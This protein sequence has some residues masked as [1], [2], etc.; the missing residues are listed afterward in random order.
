M[1]ASLQGEGWAQ[2]FAKALIIVGIL[3]CAAPIVEL[4]V[5]SAGG[6]S[7]PEPFVARGFEVDD[8]ADPFT[9]LSRI[10]QKASSHQGQMPVEVIEEMGVLPGAFESKVDAEN[11]IVGYVVAGDA[12]TI[13]GEV[14]RMMV[15]RGWAGVDLGMLDGATYMKDEGA[16]RWALVTCTQVGSKTS[17]V[18]R[19]AR[20]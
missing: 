8:V 19:F 12:E 9:T 11:D 18:V 13:S 16:L 20:A 14:D 15:D 2:R 10:E 6:G 3:V 5:Q 7:Q 4:I 1:T 17:V